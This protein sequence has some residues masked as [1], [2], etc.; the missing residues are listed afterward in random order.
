MTDA[1]WHAY[2]NVAGYLSE[3]DEIPA[4][5]WEDARG[6]LDHDIER[7]RDSLDYAPETD[8][9]EDD[10][11]QALYNSLTDALTAVR[12]ATPGQDFLA[13][14]DDGTSHTIPTAWQIV[15]CTETDCQPAE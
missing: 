1:H 11:T 2:S 7:E 15:S 5:D 3:Q 9:D 12:N 14:T 6:S 8:S 4:M 10:R 13:Y